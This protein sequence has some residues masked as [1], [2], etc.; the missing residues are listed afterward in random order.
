MAD[1]DQYTEF[2][3][4]LPVT[5]SD[6]TLMTLKGHLLVEQA[7]RTY[8][9]RRVPHPNRLKDKQIPFAN[10]IDF[11][12]S[13]EDNKNME[14]I[15]E[16]LRILNTLRNKLAHNLTPLKIEEIEARFISYVKK[17]DGELTVEA[18]NAKLGYDQFPL[19]IFQLYDRLLSKS[20]MSGLSNA[21]T[22]NQVTKAIEKAFKAVEAGNPRS[23]P[24]SR[25]KWA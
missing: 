23:G 17:H 12:S 19:A 13:L 6:K 7:L 15:W 24:K 8:I 5:A 2:L 1:L 20:T 16:A 25:K 18:D 3:T 9:S 11:A 22:D 14:W 10:L 4:H 21:I